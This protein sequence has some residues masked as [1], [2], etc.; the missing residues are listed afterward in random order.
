MSSKNSMDI[1]NKCL[2]CKLG[3]LCLRKSRRLLVLWLWVPSS[4]HSCCF[5]W[6][7]RSS[8][9]DRV[10]TWLSRWQN[11]YPRLMDTKT[12]CKSELCKGILLQLELH[13]LEPVLL[14]SQHIHLDMLNCSLPSWRFEWKDWCT[15]ECTLLISRI[16]VRLSSSSSFRR[17]RHS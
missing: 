9:L 5:C 12:L 6:L 1:L 8:R 3:T 4:Y 10:R 15:Q 14:Q 2:I 17:R 13:W 16:L 7:Q 11:I